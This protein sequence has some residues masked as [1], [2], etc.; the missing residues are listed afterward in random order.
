MW[1]IIHVDHESRLVL[2]PDWTTF[3]CSDCP[4]PNTSTFSGGGVVVLFHIWA[5]ITYI[6][7]K[8]FFCFYIWSGTVVFWGLWRPKKIKTGK[9]QGVLLC[10][11]YC[12]SMFRT[13]SQCGSRMWWALVDL[14]LRNFYTVIYLSFCCCW[15]KRAGSLSRG[16]R[17]SFGIEI[18]RDELLHLYRLRGLRFDSFLWVKTGRHENGSYKPFHSQPKNIGGRTYVYIKA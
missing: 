13:V 16:R 12:Y 9:H 14:L 8:C 17:I 4:H 15:R 1:K 7:K 5:R 18:T 11:L 2:K 6:N 3:F 10:R